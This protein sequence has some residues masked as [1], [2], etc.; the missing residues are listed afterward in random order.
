[1]SV[2][3]RIATQIRR[4]G[5]ITFDA[6][7]E[8]A[9]YDDD[10]FFGRG[11]GAGR[12][13]RDFMT[14]PEVGPLF[15]TCV[16]RAL[17]RWW[18]H[19][20][21][22]DPFLVVEAGAG[23][24]RLAREVLRAG[25]ACLAALRYVLVERSAGL[26]AHQRELLRLEPPDEAIGPFALRVAEEELRPVPRAGPVFTAVPDL[27]EVPVDAVVLANELL[28]NLPFGIAQWDGHRWN[29]V[30]VTINDG[31]FVEV[32]VPA[33]ETDAADLERLA[34]GHALAAGTRVPIP[35]GVEAWLAQCAHAL[36]GGF[37]VLI[38]Y[39]IDFDAM[40]A[41]GAGW[42][43]TYRE[44]DRGRDALTAPGSQDITA[45]VMREQLVHAARAAGFALVDDVPQWQWLEDL[46]ISELVASGRRSWTDNAA[47][48]DLAAIAGRSRM[49]EAAALTDRSGL[50]AHRVLTFARR[51][52]AGPTGRP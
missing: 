28:D 14:S 21:R 2:A 45:D 6:F 43:R 40:T 32:M 1:V 10:G 49:N 44:H 4:E 52:P 38:D 5:A 39:V 51:A 12:R 22:P 7:M 19:L 41:R 48:G 29:E 35:R 18:R 26:R 36:C 27:P 15:G 31:G 50:G 30:R 17:D 20:G 11:R 47:R 24:G 46:G 42:L 8:L 34:R 9:L 3:D 37:V 16:A 25:P 23:T 33:L 13:G